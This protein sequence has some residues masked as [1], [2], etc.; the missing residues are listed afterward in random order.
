MARAREAE[1]GQPGS[2]I[3]QERSYSVA[4]SSAAQLTERK[5]HLHKLKPFSSSDDCAEVP[6][7][8]EGQGKEEEEERDAA[9]QGERE[10]SRRTDVHSEKERKSG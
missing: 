3:G 2:L 5:I 4:Q 8:A 6:S 7:A 10:I 9:R 1:A